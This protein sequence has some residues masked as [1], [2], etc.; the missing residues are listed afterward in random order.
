MSVHSQV[1]LVASLSISIE[2]AGKNSLPGATKKNQLGQKLIDGIF[3]AN[4]FCGN[5]E[6]LPDADYSYFLS[7]ELRADAV[8]GD[9]MSIE[10]GDRWRV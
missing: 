4:I 8:K 10:A 6:D 3:L 7:V 9:P 2:T 5:S 1:P